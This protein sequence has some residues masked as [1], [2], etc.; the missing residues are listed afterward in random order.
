M[1]SVFWW[2]V[3][4]L[5]GMSAVLLGAFGSH[6]LRSK[7]SARDLEVWETACKYQF[8]HSLAILLAI[9]RGG[10]AG[11]FPAKVFTAGI[12]LFSGSLY[13]MVLTGDRRF[14]PIT[15]IGGLGLA[16]GWLSLVFM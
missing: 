6:G 11:V 10:A 15:P 1:T 9:T 5:S 2:K 13:A 4:A 16:A 12:T 8:Y 3:G 7:V 14:G